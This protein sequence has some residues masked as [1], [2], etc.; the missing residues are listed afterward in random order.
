M[1][2]FRT[3]IRHGARLALFALFVQL[4]LAFGHSHA[5][6]HAAP[7]A[8][9]ALTPSN[10]DSQARLSLQI[11]AAGR[12]SPD[13]HDKDKPA[14]DDC[15]ICVVMSMA[16][17]LLFASAPALPL[18]RAAEFS[19]HVADAELIQLRPATT[20]FQPRAPPAP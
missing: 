10:T 5:F 6:A 2:W 4:V 14:V 1:K 15:A 13:G 9:S 3:N 17:V 12:T 11:V 16:N 8:A 18:P 7:L 20:G 19:Y